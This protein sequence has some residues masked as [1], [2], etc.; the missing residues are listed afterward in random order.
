M[1]PRAPDLNLGDG[2]VILR[3]P[4]ERDLSAIDLGI[5]DPDVVRWFGQPDSDATDVI[6]LNRRRAADGSPTLS[7][8]EG[9]G[10]CIGLVWVNAS[11]ADATV[12]SVGYW[13][14]PGARGRGL[15]T[16]A[17]RL[18]SAWAISDLGFTRLRL[19]AE[20]DN[21]RSQRVAER[22]GFRRVGVLAGNGEVDGRPID[23]VLY[24]MPPIDS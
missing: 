16:R 12:G 1:T 19:L 7:I 14:L 20:P 9:D 2:I 21:D 18:L 8:C 22:A 3:S 6:A 10:A 11:G 13:L 15:A 23:H 17:V 5:H 24:E 4:D